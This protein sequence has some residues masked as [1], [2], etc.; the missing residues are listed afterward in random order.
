MILSCTVVLY[1]CDY[2]WDGAGADA[3]QYITNSGVRH[4]TS[5]TIITMRWHSIQCWQRD[6]EDN[7]NIAQ[8]EIEYTEADDGADTWDDN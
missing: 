2:G 5:W 3:G 8:A 1:L 7:L 6:L 4:K